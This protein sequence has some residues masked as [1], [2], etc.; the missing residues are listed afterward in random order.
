MNMRI[1]ET[2]SLVRAL[3]AALILL[4]AVA[5]NGC[6]NGDNATA[7][8]STGG[9]VPRNVRTLTVAPTD[10]E[11][12]ISLSGPLRPL[13]GT[14]LSAEESGRIE[15]ILND[16][17]SRVEKGDIL[18]LQDRAL[19][20]AQMQAAAAA[21]KLSAFNYERM[22]SLFDEKAVSEIEL[23]EAKS[24]NSQ[25]E[26]QARATRIHYERAAI[27]APFSGVVSN[28]YVEL[29]QLVPAGTPSMRLVNPFILNLVG[30]VTEREIGWIQEGKQ[31]WLSFEGVEGP[32]TGIVHWVGLEADPLNGK[33]PVEV[34]IDNSDLRVRPGVIG[35]A[36]VLK[37]VHELVISIPRD[38]I[39]QHSGTPEAYVVEGGRARKRTLQLGSDQGLMVVVKHGLRAGDKLV[40]RGQRDITDGALVLIQEEA[41]E[42][43]GSISGDPLAGGSAG[44]SR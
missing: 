3:P 14:D 11:E 12:F 39:V 38:A 22:Q 26:A 42:S 36:S 2:R 18:L 20:E 25:A 28:R 1:S 37:T 44:V 35:K 5:L 17:G 13:R 16:K 41:E 8:E 9:E 29:G 7:E 30:A 24:A 31:A 19:L 10:L 40:V 4:L 23:L 27:K 32:V 34:R 21:S 43:D 15:A 33:F 6:G